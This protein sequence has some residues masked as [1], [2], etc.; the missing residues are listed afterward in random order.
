[1]GLQCSLIGDG[2]KNAAQFSW[3]SS[4]FPGICYSNLRTSDFQVIQPVTSSTTLLALQG[5]PGQSYLQAKKKP[6][7]HRLRPRR[8]WLDKMLSPQQT[9]EYADNNWGEARELNSNP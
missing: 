7:T 4:Y 5:P 8:L 1:M 2:L 3:A 9:R 6:H